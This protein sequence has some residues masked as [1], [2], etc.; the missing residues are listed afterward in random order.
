MLQSLGLIDVWRDL[1]RFE[2]DYTFYSPR[3]D[4]HSRIDY[5][6]MFNPDRH[7]IGDCSIGQRD[8]SDHS[9][10]YLKI[11]LDCAPKKTLWRLNTGMVNSAAFRATMTEE[12]KDFLEYNDND[13]V[14][15]AILWD[16]AEAFL[17]GKIIAYS[18]LLKKVKA[19][20][21]SDLE[22]KLRDL[23]RLHGSTKD[24]S[25]LLQ[26]RSIKQEIDKICSEEVEKKIRFM[27]RRYDDMMFWAS[28]EAGPKQAKLLAWRLCKQQAEKSIYKLR[29]PITNKL[30]TRLEEIQKI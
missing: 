20:K 24:P 23:E 14:N 25:A 29:D 4:T 17:R 7:R 5:F 21:L 19:K 18:A 26:M 1:N 13:E 3:H 8:L 16:T 12:L 30:S 28:Y 9:G 11:H 10:L 2:L 6:L 15:L 22:V 27:K